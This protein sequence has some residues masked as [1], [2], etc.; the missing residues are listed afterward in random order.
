MYMVNYDDE[1]SFLKFLTDNDDSSEACLRFDNTTNF[2]QNVVLWIAEKIENDNSFCVIFFRSNGA[3]QP[4]SFVVKNKQY[5]KLYFLLIQKFN[6]SL[7]AYATNDTKYLN[8]KYSFI[9][10]ENDFWTCCISTLCYTNIRESNNK[11]IHYG[12]IGSN[13]YAE[14]FFNSYNIHHDLMAI[15]LDKVIYKR[16]YVE[17][18]SIWL[19]IDS[20]YNNIFMS[21]ND[22]SSISIYGDFADIIEEDVSYLLFKTLVSLLLVENI[23]II[24]Q[25]LV[26][27]MDDNCN[28]KHFRIADQTDYYDQW[29]NFIAYDYILHIKYKNNKISSA[30]INIYCHEARCFGNVI[31]KEYYKKLYNSLR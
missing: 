22:S 6:F 7:I 28:P 17:E 12:N 5:N 31:S 19:D 11:L 21:T 30:K 29:G 24:P 3:H 9:Y 27:S 26:T 25:E 20:M 1:A 2:E 15:I 8:E 4:I 13:V 16:H 23:F 18:K 14:L 10:P